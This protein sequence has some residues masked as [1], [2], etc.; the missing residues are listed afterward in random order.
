M[1]TVILKTYQKYICHGCHL[2]FSH[3]GRNTGKEYTTTSAL[4]IPDPFLI[5]PQNN[6]DIAAPTICIRS[7]SD[8]APLPCPLPSVM[9]S[10]SDG[11]Y[12]PSDRSHMKF[13]C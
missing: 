2:D 6:S 7:I 1:S 12:A 13:W 4:R 8:T 3:S 5:C 9:L 10:S 11:S